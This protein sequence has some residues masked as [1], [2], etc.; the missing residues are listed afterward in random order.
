LRLT[1]VNEK[2]DAGYEAG[3][4]GG[5]KRYRLGNLVRR[6]GAAQGRDVGRLSRKFLRPFIARRELIAVLETWRPGPQE[7]FIAYPPSRQLNAKLRVFVDWVT[8]LF[9]RFE[10]V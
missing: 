3:V 2:F 7:V 4:V 9:A 6:S 10:G 8:Q 1:A 5:E